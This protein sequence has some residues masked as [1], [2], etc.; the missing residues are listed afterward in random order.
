[1][2]VHCHP[3]ND[4]RQ[5]GTGLLDANRATIERAEA[6]Q[7]HTPVHT[8]AKTLVQGIGLGRR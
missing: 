1:M 4:V 6:R 2:P 7:T 3:A 8:R 5:P